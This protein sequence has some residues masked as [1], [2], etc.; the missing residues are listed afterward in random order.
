MVPDTMTWQHAI[1]T[2]VKNIEVLASLLQLPVAA[3]KKGQ[4]AHQAFPLMVP[5]PYL[6][7][8][9]KGNP[10]DPLLLQVLPDIRETDTISGYIK[11]PLAESDFTPQSALVH[12][13]KSRLLVIASGSCA[14]NCRYC[15][16]RHFPYADNQL[17]NDEWQNTL[18]YIERHSHINEVIFSGG[19]PLMQKDKQLAARIQSLETLPQIKRVRFHTRLP[20]VI[21]QRINAELVD[22]VNS[23][24]LNII[25]VWHINHPNEID[26]AVIQAANTVRKAGVT[27][28]NQGVIL[29]G[30]NDTTAVQVALSERLFEAGILPYYMFTMDPVQGAAHFDVPL[31]QAQKLMGQVAAELP[32]YLVP[33]LAKEIPGQK[34]K[35]V[36]MPID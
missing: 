9:E 29:K 16:R 26:E 36:L 2:A 33:K 35:T 10:N 31:A 14:V 8:I 32:G 11:D 18:N 7:R 1:A 6:Q 19:D 27:L 17:S 28:L 3:L 20:V 12:K 25:M 13:Y 5:M 21:P 34:A 24:H 23:T 15:F 22:W 4:D 30:V